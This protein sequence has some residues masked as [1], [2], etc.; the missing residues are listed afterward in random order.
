MAK[1]LDCSI[2]TVRRYEDKGILPK[3]DTEGATAVYKD[4]WLEEL[5]KIVVQRGSV[6]FI[7][8]DG[9]AVMQKSRG[10]R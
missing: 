3:P 2:R 9:S 8:K 4:D 10:R 6:W 7:Y 5:D 1:Q